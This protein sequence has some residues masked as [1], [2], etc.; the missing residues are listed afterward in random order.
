MS[1][2][3]VTQLRK[4]GRLDEAIQMAERDLEQVRDY[5]NI[6]ALFWCLNDLYKKQDGEEKERTV[7][8]MCDL[9]QELGKLDEIASNCLEIAKASISPNFATITTA[10]EQSKKKGDAYRS[11]ATI[12]QIYDKE[13]LPNRFFTDYGW[14][15]YRALHQNPQLEI[16]E[17]KK[18]LVRYL[19]LKL[20]TPSLLHSLI[21]SEAVRIEQAVPL[22]F[23]FS[24]FLNTWNLENLRDE[25][26][27]GGKNEQ[28]Q[29]LPSL[30]EKM[31]TVYVKEMMITPTVSPSD[32]FLN[33]L[34]KAVKKWPKN[35]NLLRNRAQIRIKLGQ[36]EEACK[37][38]KELLIDAT[39]KF[40]LWSELAELVDDDEIKIALLCKALCLNTPP[41]YLG[42]IRMSL[43]QM[44]VAREMYGWAKSEL[45]KV[46]ETY[47]QQKWKLPSGYDSIE[48]KI[49][50]ETKEDTTESLYAL[51]SSKADDY[52]LSDLPSVL[53]IKVKQFTEDE[54]SPN[55]SKSKKVT[56]WVLIDKNEKPQTIK[57]KRF[58]LSFKTNNGQCFEV[59]MHNER[60]VLITPLDDIPDVEWIKKVQ[61]EVKIKTNTAGRHF[62]F[63]ENCYVHANLLEGI[64]DRTLVNGIAIRRNDGKWACV[65]I[66]TQQ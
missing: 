56:K 50:A 40:Y 17:R 45:K 29:Q 9:A 13:E 20:P 24:A 62:G 2:R 3:E 23:L 15:I 22:Q 39:D 54:T 38:Y 18:L 49:L 21:L 30:V 4:E 6:T 28:D 52:I 34:E 27:V 64:T 10:V 66:S 8:R 46:K 41:E 59:K 5:W 44:L 61:G 26:W 48:R 1:Y 36:R 65:H 31:I 53:M 33:V 51:Y 63:V 12:S 55:G 43:A 57:P 32:D 11:Y 60:P 58:G 37:L 35:A 16:K 14:V 19:D 25:D 47:E 7:A 42:R